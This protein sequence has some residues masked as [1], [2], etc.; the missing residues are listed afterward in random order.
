ME[1]RTDG[2]AGMGIP[3]ESVGMSM[4]SKKRLFLFPAI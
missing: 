4:L 1:D 3:G 2:K